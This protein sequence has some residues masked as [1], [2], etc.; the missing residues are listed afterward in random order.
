MVVRD[1][2]IV[3]APIR[4]GDQNSLRNRLRVII[5]KFIDEQ[6]QIPILI[7]FLMIKY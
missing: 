5:L 1:L 6:L 4:A 7:T 3:Q 2:P